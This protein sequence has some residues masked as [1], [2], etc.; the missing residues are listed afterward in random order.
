[1]M[2]VGRA[3]RVKHIS[4]PAVSYSA[5]GGKL[6]PVPPTL[7]SMSLHFYFQAGDVRIFFH[8]IAN[9]TTFYF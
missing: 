9:S 8:V 6:K 7:F 4:F 2:G 3:K 5:R 1:M